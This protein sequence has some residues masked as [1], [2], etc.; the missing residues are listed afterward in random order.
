[1]GAI[2]SRIGITPQKLILPHQ[3][4]SYSIPGR[5]MQNKKCITN[6]NK[7]KHEANK[8]KTDCL[9]FFVVPN[10]N[11][12]LKFITGQILIKFDGYLL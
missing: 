10:V 5:T 2:C 1:M 4:D 7:T 3:N 12:F 9:L 11:Y 8:I 6:T